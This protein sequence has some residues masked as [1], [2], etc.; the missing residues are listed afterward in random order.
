MNVLGLL[1][2]VCAFAAAGFLLVGAV[3]GRT[4][5]GG[6]DRTVVILKAVA[7]LGLAGALLAA[8]LFPLALMIL[9]A[10]GGVTG[11][12]IWRER[13]MKD[14]GEDPAG[15]VADPADAAPT[16]AGSGKM[17]A[18]E[19]ASILGVAPDADAEAVKAAHR[20]LIGQMHP[21]KGGSDYLAAKINDARAVM[22]KGVGE[23]QKSD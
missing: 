6:A 3:K 14:I 12:E 19:A 8:K 13:M 10:A 16:Q 22:L 17:T 1:A 2:L 7:W 9:L 20:R 18:S 21:D 23:L 15:G 5:S 4:I 11:I